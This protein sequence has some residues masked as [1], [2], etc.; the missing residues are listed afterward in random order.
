M[1]KNPF[2]EFSDDDLS[3]AISALGNQCDKYLGT[4][5]MMNMFTGAAFQEAR[6]T[7]L[8]AKLEYD[9]AQ[10]QFAASEQK[11][12]DDAKPLP[13]IWGHATW[14]AATGVIDQTKRR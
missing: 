1:N 11:R 14:P 5:E 13:N 12:R 7:E 2:R 10:L 3:M 6:F 9:N 8:Q 4:L